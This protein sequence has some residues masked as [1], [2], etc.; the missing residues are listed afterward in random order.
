[1]TAPVYAC[2]YCERPYSDPRGCE[3][4][5]DDPRPMRYGS[6][7]HPLS[8]GPTC[9]DCAAP[10]GTEHHAYCLATECADCHRQF[11]PGM[12]CEEDAVLTTGA[13]A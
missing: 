5:D 9:R 7:C 10:K 1:M 11:H 3:Y 2:D 6:E 8:T 13:V 4:L 12:T